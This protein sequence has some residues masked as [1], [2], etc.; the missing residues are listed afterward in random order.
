VLIRLPD[1]SLIR[2]QARAPYANSNDLFRY[3]E[4]LRIAAGES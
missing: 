3:I 2:E 1:F 4:G